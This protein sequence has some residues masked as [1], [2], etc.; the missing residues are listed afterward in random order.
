MDTR[1]GKLAAVLVRY[2]IGVRRDDLV[3]ITGSTLSEAAAVA[4]C[5]EVLAVGGHPVVSLRP[6]ACRELLLRYGDETQ[7]RFVDPIDRFAHGKINAYIGFWADENTRALTTVD[8]QRQATHSAAQR[9]IL[10]LFLKRAALP[11]DDPR[12]L[13]WVGAGLATQAAAQDAEM[14]FREYEAFVFEAGKLH[15]PDPV[16]SWKKLGAAQQR[17]ADALA[18]GREVHITTPTGTDIRFGIEGRR[19]INCCGYENFPDGEVFTGPLEDATEGVVQFDI[20][21]VHDGHEVRGVRL[22]F[23]RGRVVEASAETG[24]AF[25]HQ[26]LDQ[27]RGARIAGELALGTNY[28]IRRH[29]RNTLFDEKIGGTFH[30]ALGASYPETGGRNRS[31]LHWDLVCDLRAGGV[32]RLDGKFI[33]RDGKFARAAWPR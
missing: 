9:P 7:L 30:M 3:L 11:H 29:T 17:L 12:R 19:W 2:S 32:V 4:A 20:P 1:V 31:G 22:A 27:D 25:L 24:E 14:S 16:R 13:R 15:H 5:R 6:E 23:R 26:M 28:D 18:K 8:P 10:D 21:S 33:S